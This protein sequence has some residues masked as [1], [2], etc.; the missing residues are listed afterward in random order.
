MGSNTRLFYPVEY[1][2]RFFLGGGLHVMLFLQVQATGV[3]VTTTTLTLLRTD[4]TIPPHPAPVSKA[5]LDVKICKYSV[6]IS[7]CFPEAAD[8]WGRDLSSRVSPVGRS[9]I[10]HFQTPPLPAHP[11]SKFKTGNCHSPTL[12]NTS[13]T[14]GHLG[15]EVD[16]L[17]VFLPPQG[18][19]G[20]E[21]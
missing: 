4:T 16:T 18:R 1:R 10:H 9:T 19:I 21:K 20:L 13:R 5:P 17:F 3:L 14:P 15:F 11:K 7:T 6:L 8:H 2:T 12:E